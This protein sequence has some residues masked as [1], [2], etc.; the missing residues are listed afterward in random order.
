MKPLHS[1]ILS[2]ALL[3]GAFGQSELSATNPDDTRLLHSPAMSQTHI[4]FIYAEDLWIANRDGSN[5][6]RLTIDE[7]VESNPIF[8]P[9]GKFIAFSAEYDGNQDIFIVPAKGGVPKRLTWHPYQDYVCD[10]S[11]DGSKVLFAS[12][13]STFTNRH[14]QLFTV[15][16][17]GGQIEKLPIPHAFHASYAANAKTIAYTPIRDRYDQWKNYRGGTQSRIWVYQ[18]NNHEV[19]EVPKTAAG[20]NDSYPVYM[21]NKLYFI[22]DREGEFNLFSFDPKKKA[23]QQHSEFEDFPII[24]ISAGPDGIIYEQGGYLHTFD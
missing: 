21:G 11:P 2:L 17:E 5:P 8:S 3:L 4:A 20:S 16:I 19:V 15:P 12:Q 10:F 7:G 13:R 1:F 24:D 14:A 22:S 18:V 6:R 9:D 23:V